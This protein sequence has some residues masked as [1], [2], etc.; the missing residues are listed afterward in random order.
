[1]NLALTAVEEV[2][3]FRTEAEDINESAEEADMMHKLYCYGHNRENK[4]CLPI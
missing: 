4:Q 2:A 1:M 3:D